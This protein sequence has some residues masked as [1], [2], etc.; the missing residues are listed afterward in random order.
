MA[1]SSSSYL[2][3]ASLINY[4]CKSKTIRQQIIY[5]AIVG[6]TK[7]NLLEMSFFGGPHMANK[8]KGAQKKHLLVIDHWIDNSTLFLICD[9]GTVYM[10][11]S[12]PSYS[13]PN[14]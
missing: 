6:V 4:Q 5:F 1:F 8:L 10:P 2:H 12:S 7:K 11:Y 13:F 14:K 9:V 3:S